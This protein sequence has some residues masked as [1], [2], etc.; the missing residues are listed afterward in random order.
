MLQG[1]IE[2]IERSRMGGGGWAVSHEALCVCGGGGRS[3]ILPMHCKHINWGRKNYA[4]FV[5][6]LDK[7]WPCK[8]GGKNKGEGLVGKDEGGWGKG[9]R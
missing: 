5:M 8:S 4:H 2:D 6:D 7:H 1:I 9:K 3:T